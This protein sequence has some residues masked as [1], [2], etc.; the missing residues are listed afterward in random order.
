MEKFTF[1]AV[2]LNGAE[3]KHKRNGIKRS[4]NGR[5]SVIITLRSCRV[6]DLNVRES[7]RA[8]TRDELQP[9]PVHAVQCSAVKKEL[10]YHAK[11]D[12]RAG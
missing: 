9:A 2:R 4:K 8:L 5:A 12:A 3:T 6:R 10:L 1:F 7:M 11:R